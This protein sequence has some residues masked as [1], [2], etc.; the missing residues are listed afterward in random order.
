MPDMVEVV[1][2][3]IRVGLMSQQRVIIL[4]EVEAERYLAIWIDPFMAETITLALQE[5]EVMRP[6]THDLLKNILNTM[7]TRVV[8]VEV[9]ALRGDVYYGNIVLEYDGQVL[10]VDARPSDCLALAVRTNVPILVSEEVMVSAGIIPEED[11]SDEELPSPA[12]PT[13]GEAGPSEERLSIFEDFLQKLDTDQPDEEEDE[14][15]K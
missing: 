6:L 4:R 14:E 10:D 13:G 12:E 5:A 11:L 8:R 3:S 9:L 7:N 15:D 1:I 2:D